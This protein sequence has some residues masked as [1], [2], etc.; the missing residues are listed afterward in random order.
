[1]DNEENNCSAKSVYLKSYTLRVLYKVDWAFCT[2][3]LSSSTLESLS[4]S[5]RQMALL[6]YEPTRIIH[7]KPIYFSLSQKEK[8]NIYIY[9]KKKKCALLVTL[10]LTTWLLFWKYM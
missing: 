8:K 1:M 4:V 6:S 7:V 5:S 10:L 9:K 2:Y 3:N